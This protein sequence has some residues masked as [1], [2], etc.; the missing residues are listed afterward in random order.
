MAGLKEFKEK[1]KSDSAFAE[2]V[3]KCRIP[4]EIIEFAEK[5]GFSFT[6]EDIEELTDVSAEDI[7]RVSGGVRALVSASNQIAG[8]RP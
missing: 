2:A 8:R 6:A 7:A 3:S 5:N 1:M 4:D